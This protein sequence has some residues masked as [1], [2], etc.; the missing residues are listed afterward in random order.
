MC[1]LL[2]RP[3]MRAELVKGRTGEDRPQKRTRMEV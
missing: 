3:V 2:G 1:R